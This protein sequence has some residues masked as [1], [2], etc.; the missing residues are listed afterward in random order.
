MPNN[1][2]ALLNRLILAFNINGVL[3]LGKKYG[4]AA[5]VY[6]FQQIRNLGLPFLVVGVS[7]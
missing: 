5:R 7:G 6:W 3:I 2:S 4:L 1:S